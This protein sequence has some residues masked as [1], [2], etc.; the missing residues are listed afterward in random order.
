MNKHSFTETPALPLHQ[1]GDR[2]WRRAMGVLIAAGV[3]LISGMAYAQSCSP[4]ETPVS[5]AFTGGEQTATVPLGVHSLTVY[6]SGAQG[7]AGRSGAGTIGGSPN[8][9]GGVGGLGGRVRGTLAVTP[10]A[11]LSVWVGGQGSQVV[12]PGGIGEGVDGIGGGGTDLRVNGNTVAN[13]VAIAGGGGG[14]GNAGWSTASVI[15]GGNGGVGGGGVGAAGADVPGGPGPYG[16]QGGTVGTGGAG[17]GGCGSFP[18]TVGN[19][20]NG[21]GGDS[22]NFSGSFSGAGFGGG[23]GGG[24]TVGAGGGGAGVGTTSCQQNWNGGGGGGSGGSSA[25]TGLTAVALMN[26]VQLGNGAALICFAPTAFSVG[27]TVSGQTGPVSL[28]LSATNP[29]SNQSLV[30]A[31]AASSFVFPTLLPQGANWAINVT[32]APPGQLCSASAA[33]GSSINADV[34]NVV[35]SCTTVVVDVNPPSLPS[36]TF[37]NAY[38]QTLTAS[39]ANGAVGPYSYTVSAGVLPSGTALSPA[40][41]ISGTPNAANIFNFSIQATSSNGFAG[42][43]AYTVNVLRASQTIT[44]MAASPASPV[45]SQGGSFTVSASGGASGSP[46]VFSVAPASA[47]VCAASGPNGAT[48]QMLASGA[49]QL[50]ANQA[51]NANYENAAPAS[52]SVPITKAAQTISAVVATPAN[53]VFS[54]GGTFAVSASGG[55]SSEP[56]I[57]SV[58]ASSASVC[59]AAGT[60]G[61]LITTHSAGTCTVQANQ[62]GD[63][64]YQ[65]AA[66]RVQDI[67][68]GKGAQ[69]ISIS[70]VQPT[71]PRVGESYEVVTVAG[72]STA[73][74]TLAASGACSAVAKTVSFDAVGSCTITASQ[75]GDA[76]YLDAADVTQTM[77]VAQGGS[78]VEIGS[79]PNPS[80]PA[81]SVTFTVTVAFD[82]TKNA[83]SIT[84]AAP[85]PSGTV[86]ITDGTTVL[87]SAPLQA[88][89]A[90]ISTQQLIVVG[91][92]QI[93]ASYSG[94]ANYP[95]TQS[96]AFVQTVAA[97]PVEQVPGLQSLA[98][99]LLSVMA[100]GIGAWALRRRGAMRA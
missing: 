99:A 26:G 17:G 7:G 39:S 76:N 32:S 75:K 9:P 52:L 87:G 89:V 27:G 69:T 46:V 12:N 60:N 98:L 79:S 77:V 100:A 64:N 37:G 59:S 92:H 21:D 93:V 11:Q 50:L 94:D 43:R 84:K 85:I 58:A 65:A 40:G 31:Q 73:P 62:A 28:G 4:G 91:D 57:F 23:G 2:R 74:L 1:L 38:S 53:P 13:R 71:N 14:G 66:Q 20:A 48:I 19:A 96:S 51:G 78:G 97:R 72:P 80:L 30:I 88:G 56:V 83:A 95:A 47:A 61:A 3:W 49:C 86:E 10:G 70:S 16:G 33:S 34:S 67:A 29:S 35:V 36:A 44:N 22:F 6:L 90:T 5:F 24:A 8:S 18:A 25:A 41:V 54:Q 45:F 63:A 55:G 15:E 68:I 42:Q 82:A 81:Q